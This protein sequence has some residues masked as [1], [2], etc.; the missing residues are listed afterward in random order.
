MMTRKDYVATAEILNIFYQ[1]LPI[2]LEDKFDKMVN[3]FCDMFEKDNDRFL[4]DKF[5]DACWKVED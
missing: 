2:G 5:I 3:D 1:E 4:S